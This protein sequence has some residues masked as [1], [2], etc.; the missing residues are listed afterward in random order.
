MTNLSGKELE[1]YVRK[2]FPT[3][4]QDNGLEIYADILSG[5]FVINTGRYHVEW[6]WKSKI[7]RIFA[8]YPGQEIFCSP[9]DG[10][11]KLFCQFDPEM[12]V[13]I[14][15]SREDVDVFIERLLAMRVFQ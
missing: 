7:F 15:S 6:F 3:I 10:G 12:K 1:D 2:E 13:I 9:I 8:Q 14:H 4:Y 11:L 5:C